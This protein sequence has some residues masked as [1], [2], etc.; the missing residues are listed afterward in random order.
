MALAGMIL[1]D[2][3]PGIAPRSRAVDWGKGVS[4]REALLSVSGEWL[5][6]I[7]PQPL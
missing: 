5:N 2:C 4:I 1:S 7:F 6:V 3:R